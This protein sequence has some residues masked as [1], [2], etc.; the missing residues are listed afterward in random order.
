VDPITLSVQE[1][2]NVLGLK[3]TT[4]FKLISTNRLRVT[5]VGRRTL[6]HMES[7]RALVDGK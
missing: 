7:I 6:V 5:R 2:I 1:T 4:I 3:R